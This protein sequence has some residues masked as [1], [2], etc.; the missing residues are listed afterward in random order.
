MSF[1]SIV[2]HVDETPAA[3]IRAEIAAEIARDHRGTAEALVVSIAPL[4]PYG[5]GAMALGGAFESMRTQIALR[6]REQAEGIARAVM[7]AQKMT[8]HVLDTTTDRVMIEVGSRLRTADLTVIA[9]PRPNGVYQDDDIFE[10]AVF[11]AGCPAI[12]VPPSR[13]GA[14]VG[15]VVAIAWKDCR[16]AARAIHD[17]L[18]ILHK[19]KE[20]RLVVVHGDD[21]YHGHRALD[22]M[23]ESLKAR[24]IAVG[25]PIIEQARSHQSEALLAAA[26]KSGADLLVMGA[27]GR[28][29]MSEMLFGGFTQHVLE[30]ADIPVFLSH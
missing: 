28:W 17:A 2:V 16:E 14:P 25:A 20:V 29:R 1:R 9:P 11:G 5:P 13:D 22:R 6:N 15:R 23:Q 8:T 7:A 24:G 26:Q 10:A 19:A 18:P 3:L 21:A 27:Y 12:L 4:Q 30:H